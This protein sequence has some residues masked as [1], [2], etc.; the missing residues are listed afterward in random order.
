[1][2]SEDPAALPGSTAANASSRRKLPLDGVLVLDFS[3]LLPG[4]WCTQMLGDLGA[5]VI[6]IE[7]PG[8]GDPSRHN[9]PRNRESSVYFNTVNR[10]K[11]SIALDLRSAGGKEVVGRL[12]KRADVIVESFSVGVAARLEI[13]Y[14]TVR[15]LNPR[16][17]YCSITGF[18]QEGPLA[19]S[20]GHDLVLQ[21]GT[22]L[23]NVNGGDGTGVHVPGFQAAD[24]AGSVYACIGILAAIIKQRES[25]SGCYLDIAM[26]DSLFSMCNIV[27][28]GALAQ[29]AGSADA[30]RMQV[31]GA[32]PR[33]AVYRTADDKAVAVS[34]LETR[35]W[36]SFCEFI[37][38]PDLVSV[39]ESPADRHSDHG[40]R[41]E[42]Y[43]AAITEYCS[44][45]TRDEISSEMQAADIPICPVLSPEEA[46]ASQNVLE[47]GLV[48][49]IDHSHEG[50]I[51]QLGNPLARAGLADTRRRPAPVLGQDTNALLAEIGY[52]ELER[53]RLLQSG[54]FGPRP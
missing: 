49:S 32:N 39:D 4:P 12:I 43:R 21:C 52:S 23:M 18:G 34:L 11:R 33:Y 47:R 50:A 10:N 15:R 28:T 37:G 41:S 1:M 27:L 46:I 29:A 53:S 51:L 35:L 54:A 45:R 19:R 8:S 22:G 26:F 31:W 17:V 9:A 42:E 30:S 3:R 24:Y 7:A 36:K 6:K 5:E 14:E 2:H 20:P 13:D 44:I 16:V 25:R 40:E 48:E 38:R